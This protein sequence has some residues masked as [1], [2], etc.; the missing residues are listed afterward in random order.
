MAGERFPSPFLSFFRHTK[1]FHEDGSLSLNEMLS[2]SETARKIRAMFKNG[3]ENL[4]Y[5][6][7]ADV[8]AALRGRMDTIRFLMPLAHFVCDANKS[9][10]MV[11]FLTEDNF[12]PGKIPESDTCPKAPLLKKINRTID[13][14][15]KSIFD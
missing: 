1:L 9:R 4:R 10:S 7:Q 13:F 3:R 12:A 15:A 6:N 8:P 5:A 2:H 14:L 11:G